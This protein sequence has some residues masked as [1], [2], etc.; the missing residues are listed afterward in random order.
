MKIFN[1]P[2]SIFNV[3]IKQI[4]L[5]GKTYVKIFQTEC[6]MPFMYVHLYIRNKHLADRDSRNGYK[7][8]ASAQ[9]ESHAKAVH[10]NNVA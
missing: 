1:F 6:V 9:T 2:H 4:L 3:D 7:L 8:T 5:F 10:S